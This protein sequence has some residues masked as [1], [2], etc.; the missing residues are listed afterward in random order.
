[1]YQNT[2][3]WQNLLWPMSM[4]V[5][6]LSIPPWII[7]LRIAHSLP[8]HR[9]STPQERL[10]AQHL[11]SIPEKPHIQ[12]TCLFSDPLTEDASLFLSLMFSFSP[13]QILPKHLFNPSC[14]S[15]YITCQYNQSWHLT[16][17]HCQLCPDPCAF[18]LSSLLLCETGSYAIQAGLY[19]AEDDFTLL[20]IFCL[21]L[22]MLGL[23]VY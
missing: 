12:A 21:H 7:W 10:C 23:K 17:Q 6:F 19:A 14:L 22:K 11:Y 9:I 15:R 1:M 16:T 13:I 3:Q 20:L 2:C 8:L 18:F 5:N 4:K